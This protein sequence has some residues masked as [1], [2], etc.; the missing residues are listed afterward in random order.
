METIVG[1]GIGM[2]IGWL[3]FHSRK[4][5]EQQQKAGQDERRDAASQSKKQLVVPRDNTRRHADHTVRKVAGGAAAGAVLGYMLSRDNKTEANERIQNIKNYHE[6]DGVEDDL[7]HEDGDYG[8]YDEHAEYDYDEEEGLG[9][10]ESYED[11]DIE[12]EW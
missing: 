8:E 9:G 1:I 12:D 10:E 7:L 3:V 6:F 2:A 4:N 11:D 5:H